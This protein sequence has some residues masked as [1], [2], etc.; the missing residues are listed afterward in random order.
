MKK[1]LNANLCSNLFIYHRRRPFHKPLDT[2]L[3]P[4]EF[5]VTFMA[6]VTIM[7]TKYSLPEASHNTHHSSN[8]KLAEEIAGQQLSG[9]ALI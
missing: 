2:N 4:V 5:C 7:M 8:N 9:T 3:R 1:N 6:P